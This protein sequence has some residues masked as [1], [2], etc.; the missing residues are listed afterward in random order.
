[1]ETKGVFCLEGPW[2]NDLGDKSSVRPI[3]ELLEAR[4]DVKY[5]YKDCVEEDEFNYYLSKWIQVKYKKKYPIL[6]LA[7]H[8]KKGKICLNNKVEYSI[9]KM[10]EQ[11]AGKCTNAIIILG[12]CSTMD[13]NGHKLRKFLHDT[14][15][16]AIL[17][18]RADVDWIQSTAFELLMLTTLQENRFDGRGIPAIQKKLSCLSKSFKK[19]EFRI[20]TQ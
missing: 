10:S 17:G 18:Y 20:A 6:Y 3:L 7:F 16:C 2:E 5:V 4:S 1:M 11:L 12:S 14:D 13:V 8:G 15:A 9:L 19:L